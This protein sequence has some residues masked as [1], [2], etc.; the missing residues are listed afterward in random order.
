MKKYLFCTLISAF[1][2]SIKAQTNMNT[3]NIDEH[4][5]SYTAKASRFWITPELRTIESFKE[6]V[7]DGEK[8]KIIPNNLRRYKHVNPNALPLGNDPIWQKG[9]STH[10]NKAPIQNWEGTSFS[11][12]PPD[13]SGAAGPNH[14]V[15]MVNTSYTIYDKTGNTLGGPYT[16]SSL[17]GGSN[18][19]DPIVMYDAD[20]DRWFLSQFKWT[21]S[22]LQVAVS[23]TSDPLG[24]YYAYEFI[25]NSF[26][27]YPKYSVWGD[28]YYVTSNKSA[29]QMYA[30][31]RTEMIAGNPNAQII[32][33]TVPQVTTNGFFS[34]QP[35]NATSSNPS[36][37]TPGYAFYFQDDGWGGISSDHIKIWE[38]NLDWANTSNSSISTPQQLNVSPFDSEFNSSWNDIQQP[39]T[40]S[41]LDGIPTAFMYMAQYREFSSYASVVLNHTVDVNGSN[42]GGIRWYELRKSGSNPW[43]LYQEGT[44]APDNQSRWLG[45]ICMD[46]Q[47]NIALA[48][49]VSGSTV[50]PSIRYTGRYFSDPLGQMTLAEED[51][52]VGSGIQTGTNRWGDYS[53]MTIDPLDDAT[54]WYTGEYIVGG[55][56]SRIASFKIANDANDDIGVVSVD[57][58]INGS[59]SANET[60]TVTVTNFG[61]N[62]Q[63]NFPIAYSLNSGASINETFSGTLLSGTSAQHTFSTTANMSVQG[64]HTITSYTSLSNDQYLTNDTTNAIIQHLFTNDVGVS[65]ITAPVT[66]SNLTSSEI[67]SVIIENFGAISQTNIPIYYS[68]GGAPPI[69]E[70]YT[71]TLNPG[72]SRTYNFTT[73]A[74]LSV[75]GTYNFTAYT[76]LTGDSNLNNDTSYSEVIKQICMPSGDCSSGD[77]FTLFKLNTINNPSSCSNNGYGDFTSMI[78]DLEQGSTNSLILQSGFSGQSGTVWIDLNDN[79]TFETSER[80]IHNTSFGTSFTTVNLN[81]PISA[82]LG[83]HLLRARSNWNFFGNAT[84]SDPCID[85]TYGETEDYTVNIISPTGNGMLDFSNVELVIKYLGEDEFEISALNLNRLANIEIH[86]TIGQKVYSSMINPDEKQL[87]NLSGHASGYYLVHIS[88]DDFSFIKKIILE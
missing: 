2:F 22:S 25:L 60:I 1:V 14:Y 16:L 78:T 84:I 9:G 71:D 44:F 20:A 15:H 77:G 49:S 31:E 55:A 7:H 52:I 79:F 34:I 74:D 46:Y 54:F 36:A 23:Q 56:K 30:L 72:A 6:I 32:G 53:Q 75:L 41:K 4:K 59:L 13:P 83:Q 17:L 70:T 57:N 69:S 27:D 39:G 37:G 48:Y 12:T 58:P 73:T 28:A 67:V 62:D 47:G 18:D 35:A 19:G 26:P 50:Y 80:L 10:Y 68:I 86:N 45:S 82:N 3:Q 40:S 85:V 76:N 38:M 88:G 81:I 8:K 61:I 11:A 42:Q 5:A 43:T 64:S 33:F 24:A 87:V 51:I 21:N 29:P 66:G 63:S 65:S